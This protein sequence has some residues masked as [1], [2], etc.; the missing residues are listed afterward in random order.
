M[1][2]PERIIAVSETVRDYIRQN[3]PETDMGKVMLIHR[4]VDPDEFPRGYRPSAT[5]LEDW[6]RQYPQL[7]GKTI[8]TL[9]G[10]VSRLKG[11]HDFIH[12]LQ[13]LKKQGLDCYGLIVGDAGTKHQEYA[14]ELQ[15]LVIDAGLKEN[16]IFTGPRGD[17]REIYTVS[18]LILSLSRKPESF[19][20]TVVEALSIGTPVV[21]Y[22]HGGVSEI[23]RDIFPLGLVPV[24]D[25]ATLF[26]RV[27]TLLNAQSVF[28]NNNHYMLDNMLDLTIDCYKDLLTESH[29][30]IQY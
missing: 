17:M 1:C 4:G 29:K 20:R 24:K 22:D 3:Y 9:P 15:Q 5:W 2:K 10:R 8:I 27:M 12:L 26:E 16:V 30:H 28:I 14:K 25:P 6:H 7:I 21:G 18:D 11:H 19:G 13:N 23:L